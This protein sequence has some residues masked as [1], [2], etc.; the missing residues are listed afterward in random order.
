M[1]ECK[2]GPYDI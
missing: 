2:L 1:S